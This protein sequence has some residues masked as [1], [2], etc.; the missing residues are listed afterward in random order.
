MKSEVVRKTMKARPSRE[1]RI[2]APRAHDVKG[3]FGMG[4]KAVPKVRREVRV[5]G[6]EGGDKVVLACPH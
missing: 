3:K 2:G 1:G 6:G 5:G 4:E